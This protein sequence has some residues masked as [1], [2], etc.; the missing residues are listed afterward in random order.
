MTLDE[1]WDL[2]FWGS[3]QRTFKFVEEDTTGDNIGDWQPGI[4]YRIKYSA[5]APTDPQPPRPEDF[6]FKTE[7]VFYS[8]NLSNYVGSGQWFECYQARLN[9]NEKVHDTMV[10]KR[11][12]SNATIKTHLMELRVHLVA[13]RLLEIFKSSIARMEWDIDG[14]SSVQEKVSLLRV[15]YIGYCSPIVQSVLI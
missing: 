14:W 11:F 15:C 8:I 13:A 9:I 12:Y 5:P 6:L 3:H 4:L 10:A 2:Q 7:R 1:S